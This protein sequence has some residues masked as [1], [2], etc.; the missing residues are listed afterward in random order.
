MCKIGQTQNMKIS[1]A[2]DNNKVWTTKEVWPR[3]YEHCTWCQLDPQTMKSLRKRRNL[4]L[5]IK[6]KTALGTKK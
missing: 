5:A 6:L 3:A 4:Q 1:F 2:K